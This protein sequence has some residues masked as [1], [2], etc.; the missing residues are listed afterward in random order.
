MDFYI[1]L[2]VELPN[3]ST[4]SNEEENNY[5]DEIQSYSDDSS[6]SGSIPDPTMDIIENND[7]YDRY[8]SMAS[9]HSHKLSLLIA[10]IVFIH[11]L[12]R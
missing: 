12:T 6:S 2:L 4:E 7:L 9:Q 3:Y 5:E 8:H 11:S 10:S 1:S